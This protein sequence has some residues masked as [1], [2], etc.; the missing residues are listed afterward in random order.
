VK[1]TDVDGRIF[2]SLSHGMD[3]SLRGLF[4]LVVKSDK[5]HN[6]FKGAEENDFS[7]NSEYQFVCS[8]KIYTFNFNEDYTLAVKLK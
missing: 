4:D 1:S 6:L 3:A 5:K 8:D 7:L 2:K